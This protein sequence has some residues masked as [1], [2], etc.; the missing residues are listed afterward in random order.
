MSKELN[1][2]SWIRTTKSKGFWTSCKRIFYN[3]WTILKV[4]NFSHC[5]VHLKIV[6]D[7]LWRI[8]MAAALFHNMHLF[9]YFGMRENRSGLLKGAPLCQIQ[10]MTWRISIKLI[11]YIKKLSTK[12]VCNNLPLSNCQSNDVGYTWTM[13]HNKNSSCQLVKPPV[14]VQKYFT[15]WE[16]CSIIGFISSKNFK[17]WQFL[18]WSST[19]THK[20]NLLT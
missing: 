17:Y 9:A 19:K 3:S 4:K 1:I 14:K 7:L 6:F 12:P 8:L 18:Q 10:V 2:K 15:T 13:W 11:K 16:S 5:H 20:V